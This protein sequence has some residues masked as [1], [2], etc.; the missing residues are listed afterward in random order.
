L[1]IKYQNNGNRNLKQTIDE[2]NQIVEDLDGR[3]LKTEINETISLYEDP[4]DED[5][6]GL[7]ES[8]GGKDTKDQIK[9]LKYLRDQ[10]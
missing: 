1:K 9:I 2:Y 8:E 5:E 6:A 7:D 4:D 3:D 10:N